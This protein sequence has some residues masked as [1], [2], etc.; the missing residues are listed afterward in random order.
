MLTW[1]RSW[2][3][4]RQAGSASWV[5]KFSFLVR[6]GWGLYCCF[7]TQAGG[8][9]REFCT[10]LPGGFLCSRTTGVFLQFPCQLPSSY[11]CTTSLEAKMPY[12]LSCFEGSTL[13][14]KTR[15]SS[16]VN[17]PLCV[18]LFWL[19][20]LLLT[21]DLWRSFQITPEHKN[22]APVYLT[23]EQMPN[24]RGGLHFNRDH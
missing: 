10:S 4:S 12:C 13:F 1:E 24:I 2:V 21:T 9:Q 8:A 19:L 18:Q 14:R 17:G 23:E 7:F 3:P 6:R 16:K 20:K 11:T 5:L 22:L 15:A